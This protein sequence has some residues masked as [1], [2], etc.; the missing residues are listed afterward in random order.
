MRTADDLHAQ[1]YDIAGR[2]DGAERDE[3]LA[4]AALARPD[5]EYLIAAGVYERG[6][7]AEQML[8]ILSYR[9][10]QAAQSKSGRA[11][12]RRG[13]GARTRA[14]QTA[15]LD[16]LDTFDGPMS[17]RQVFYRCVSCGAVAN[18]EAGYD[19]VQRLLVNMR[20]EGSVPYEKIVDRNRAK[21]HR[22]GWD[23][24]EDGIESLYV[25]FRRNGWTDQDTVVMVGLEK[26]AL[27]GIFAQVVD[28]YGASLWTATGFSSLSFAFDWAREIRTHNAR[29]QN[30]A[31]AFF[32]D[33]DPS[34]LQIEAKI[35][36]ELRTHGARFE[37]QR[38]GLLWEDFEA[39]SLVNVPVKRGDSRAKGYLER[40]GDRAAEL[41]ALPPDELR[42]R[43]RSAIHAHLDEERWTKIRAEEAFNRESLR[44]VSSHWDAALAAARSA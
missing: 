27:E 36:D 29:G 26:L 15:I 38:F 35:Q 17:T 42:A 10:E 5:L 1:A 30:V 14:L 4:V 20:R 34:G 24:V 40:F 25:Q 21:H 22:P 32:G 2:C 18:D 12:N 33:H 3:W 31:I 6:C 9:E 39:F 28:D 44:M 43:V 19:K 23:A 11:P 13:I 8:E 7:T 41:D 16:E 37:W